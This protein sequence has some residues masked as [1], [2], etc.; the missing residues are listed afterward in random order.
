MILNPDAFASYEIPAFPSSSFHEADLDT[1]T[2]A[3][4][5][6]V[7]EMSAQEGKR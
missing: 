1:D 6:A 2:D 7:L 5:N 4:A 3:D